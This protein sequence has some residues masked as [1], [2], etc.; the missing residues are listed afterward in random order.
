MYG[1]PD[2]WADEPLDP[3]SGSNIAR[4]VLFSRG[5]Q[6]YI[7]RTSLSFN[8]FVFTCLSRCITKIK[9]IATQALELGYDGDD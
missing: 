9:I 3:V 2:V 7:A 8:K 1:C 6:M 4:C 5:H